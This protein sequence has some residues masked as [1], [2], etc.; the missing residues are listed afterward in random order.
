M[1]ASSFI[2]FSRY[3]VRA[4]FCVA[5]LLLIYLI[6]TRMLGLVDNFSLSL[7]FSALSMRL[8]AGVCGVLFLALCLLVLM[9]FFAEDD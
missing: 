9:H 6:G 3:L 4:V 1:A 7:G 2:S 5:F 8:A